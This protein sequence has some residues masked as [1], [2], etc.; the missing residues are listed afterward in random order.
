M[1]FRD[2]CNYTVR[3]ETIWRSR[4]ARHFV[5]HSLFNFYKLQHKWRKN[6]Y[7]P[8]PPSFMR[9]GLIPPAWN[10]LK[11]V[12]SSDNN[13]GKWQLSSSP[14]TGNRE[15]VIHVDISVYVGWVR[16]GVRGHE[17]HEVK[18]RCTVQF[19]SKQYRRSFH[20]A[21]HSRLT[22]PP[23]HTRHGSVVYNAVNIIGSM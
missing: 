8:A 19:H 2:D 10:R 15:G 1:D 9:W 16:G 3:M 7:T 22:K 13:M 5:V 23:N 12:D 21:L 14:E 17:P 6:L 20:K 18:G 4:Q 11:A